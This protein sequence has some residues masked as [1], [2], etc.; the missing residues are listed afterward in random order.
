[1]P[2][3]DLKVKKCDVLKLCRKSD[4]RHNGIENTNIV[5]E[6]TMIKNDNFAKMA[7]QK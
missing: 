4:W 1:M 2:F 3:C 7:L 5:A 6:I